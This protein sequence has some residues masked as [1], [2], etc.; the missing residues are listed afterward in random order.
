M[1]YHNVHGSKWS[2]CRKL[3]RGVQLTLLSP[4]VTKPE[5][6]KAMM[7]VAVERSYNLVDLLTDTHDELDIN[8]EIEKYL[9]KCENDISEVIPDFEDGKQNN[10][11]SLMRCWHG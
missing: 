5:V 2:L 3:T 6:A 11:C 4:T 10:C 1:F 7:D 8:L 9:T